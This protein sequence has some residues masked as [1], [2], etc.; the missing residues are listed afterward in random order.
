MQEYDGLLR[1]LNEKKQL[2][3]RFEEVSLRML[4]CE[5]DDLEDGMEERGRL[6]ERVDEV[7]AQM[8]GFCEGAGEPAL[9]RVLDP[10][11]SRGELP[12]WAA[13]LYD[14][15]RAADAIGVRL[16]ESNAQLLIRLEEVRERTLA[17]IRE[18]NRG[19][20]AQAAKY[21]GS[22]GARGGYPGSPLGKA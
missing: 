5:D 4:L 7:E 18:S 15:A 14:A 13:P 6:I 16:Q 21:Y 12:G 2:L 20:G 11:V 17:Q 8:R 9:A 10:S 3:E 19:Q 22:M 1:L